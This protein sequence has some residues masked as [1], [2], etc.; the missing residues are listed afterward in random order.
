M[1]VDDIKIKIK[2]GNGGDGAVA[3]NKNLMS[4]GPVGGN[5]GNAGSIFVEGIVDITALNQFRFKKLI[6]TE[7]GEMGHGQSRNGNDS[8]DVTLKVPVGTVIHNLTTSKDVEIL[9]LNLR[10]QFPIFPTS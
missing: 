5:G 8:D 9:N 10:P 7:N 6:K 1:I 3:F 4:L 2:A